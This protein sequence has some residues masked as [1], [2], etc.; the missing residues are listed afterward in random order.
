[1]FTPND[2]H[3]TLTASGTF[4]GLYTALMAAKPPLSMRTHAD[5]ATGLLF[6]EQD[7]RV[8][9]SPISGT[10]TFNPD[11][12]A[13]LLHAVGYTGPRWH[14]ALERLATT[15]A[16]WSW[17]P[18][19]GHEPG[20]LDGV[21]HLGGSITAETRIGRSHHHSDIADAALALI[22]ADRAASGPAWALA[23]GVLGALVT[24]DPAYRSPV[25]PAPDPDALAGPVTDY[26]AA[27]T[28]V[29][30]ALELLD[31][32]VDFGMARDHD[33]IWPAD[34]EGAAVLALRDFR[35]ALINTT[36]DPQSEPGSDDRG[37]CCDCPHEM[38]A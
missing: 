22:P 13:I 24:D 18:D 33:P 15:T 14:T 17:Q 31:E 27:I 16:A 38:E 25:L 19:P 20:T 6:F 36:P 12:G 10:I 2:L 11:N 9:N 1:M 4:N 21:L 34:A 8:R 29:A 26:P 30:A 37:G 3:H 32:N 5:Q 35:D 7:R 28:T 23:V